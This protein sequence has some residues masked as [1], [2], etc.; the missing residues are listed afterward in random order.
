MNRAERRKFNRKN[1][2]NYTREQMDAIEMYAKMRSGEISIKHASDFKDSPFFH[3]DGKALAPD[4]AEAKIRYD[5]ILSR[6][7]KL[8]DKYIEF[9]TQHK[10]EIVH[11][12]RKNTEG[13]PDTLVTL[14]EDPNSIWL[15]DIY[16][17][18]LFKN[19]AEEWDIL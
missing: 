13:K 6:S 14:E 5:D 17:D 8:N 12:S 9:V 18:L 4:G 1:H 2:T 15:F 7:E 19:E 3:F 16:S 10:E 11:I